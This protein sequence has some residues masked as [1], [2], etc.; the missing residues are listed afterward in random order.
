MTAWSELAMYQQPAPQ[1]F[2]PTAQTCA[3]CGRMNPLDRQFC[4][5]CS[6]MLARS[7]HTLAGIGGRLGA[8][9]LDGLIAGVTG[10]IALLFL[11]AGDAGPLVAAMLILGYLAGVLVFL[12][13]GQTPG[14][15][16]IG[17]V[18]VR[19][20]GTRAGF[21][22]MFFARYLIPALLSSI[23]LGIFGILDLLWALWDKD[24]RTLHDKIAGTFVVR[25]GASD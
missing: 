18:C 20:D 3:R 4:I 15:A 2:A 17:L 25:M 23:T 6:A 11:A 22:T 14:K 7:E 12:S 19:P 10:A 8:N 13:R 24:R 16:A 9:L 21:P 1:L 5:D